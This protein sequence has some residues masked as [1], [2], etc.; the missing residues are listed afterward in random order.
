MSRLFKIFGLVLGTVLLFAL[1]AVAGWTITGWLGVGETDSADD[2]LALT[3]YPLV[4]EG[5]DVEATLDWLSEEQDLTAAALTDG[6]DASAEMGAAAAGGQAARLISEP[7][8]LGES[9]G[10]SDGSN[11]S[12]AESASEG[13]GGDPGDEPLPPDIFVDTPYL[14]G[15]VDLTDVVIADPVGALNLDVCAGPTELPETPAGC[16]DGMGGTILAIDDHTDPPVMPTVGG[17]PPTGFTAFGTDTLYVRAF[18][19]SAVAETIWVDAKPWSDEWE[20]AV[21][22]CDLGDAV[23]ADAGVA[24]RF[25]RSTIP[26]DT[27]SDPSTWPYDPEFDTLDVFALG[28][29]VGTLYAVCVYWVDSSAA[30]VVSFRDSAAVATASARR[31][32]VSVLGFDSV[33]FGGHGDPVDP[34]SLLQ[35]GAVC[36]GHHGVS[37]EWPGEGRYVRPSPPTPLCDFGGVSSLLQ[38]GGFP[39]HTI[40]TFEESGDPAVLPAWVDIQRSD[41]LCRADCLDRFVTGFALPDVDHELIDPGGEGAIPPTVYRAGRL[42]LL[43]E[44]EDSAEPRHGWFLGEP[45]SVD[46]SDRVYEPPPVLTRVEMIRPPLGERA[47]PFGAGS[48]ATT[49]DFVIENDVPV[50]VSV[51][52]LDTGFGGPGGPPCVP[53]GGTAPSYTSTGPATEHSFA[54]DG[55]CLGEDYYLRVTATDAAG[56]S[57]DV[58]RRWSPTDPADLFF[59]TTLLRTGA[60]RSTPEYTFDLVAELVLGPQPGGSCQRL[61]DLT[62]GDP[63]W[64]GAAEPRDN[65]RGDDPLHLYVGPSVVVEWDAARWH[66]NSA[67]PRYVTQERSATLPSLPITFRIDDAEARELG[68]TISIEID[69]APPAASCSGRRLASDF[70]SSLGLSASPTLTEL[71]AGVTLANGSSDYPR[72]TLLAENV[73]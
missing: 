44:F 15:R 24:Y 2:H 45:V 65:S 62:V 8:A 47:Y 17:R 41:L 11:A 52:L 19:R 50:S 59:F 20:N 3:Q 53:G 34:I 55:L 40:L 54:L 58:R 48:F 26:I 36:D 29:D 1:A 38:N 56:V 6:A 27:T 43:V 64:G 32:S 10:T 68:Q 63:Y 51:E 25:P 30:S 16:P 22:G 35:V 69:V 28:L 31:V 4:Q 60:T 21:E 72:L 12:A 14:A 42:S 9:A 23:P 49:R 66:Q 57:Y 73:E 13:S 67:Q 18:R 33:N 7:V 46:T 70:S 37:F 71:L 61:G 5:E 39:A